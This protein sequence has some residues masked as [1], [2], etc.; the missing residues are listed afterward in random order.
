MRITYDPEADA[1]YIRLL[2]GDFPCRNVE[3]T[4]DVTLDF[5]PGEKLVGIEILDASHV[6]GQGKIPQVVVH[7]L[8]V[9][10]A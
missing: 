7:K 1:M 10:T 3:V 9:A 5:G 8:P 2:E 6:V 4:Q